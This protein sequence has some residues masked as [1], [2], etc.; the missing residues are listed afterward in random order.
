MRQEIE[1][2]T[3]VEVGEAAAEFGPAAVVQAFTTGTM[4]QVA[5]DTWT[6]IKTNAE[7]P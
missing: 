1:S 2:I 4:V 7:P 3:G 5:G 6:N